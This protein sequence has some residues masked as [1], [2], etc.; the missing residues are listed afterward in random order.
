[1]HASF[2]RTPLARAA[3]VFVCVVKALV[4]VVSSRGAQAQASGA[5]QSVGMAFEQGTAHLGFVVFEREVIMAAAGAS[6]IGDFT[7]DPQIGQI[8]LQKLAR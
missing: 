2:V 3:L 4:G 7:A 1:M 5:A 8:L 6:K